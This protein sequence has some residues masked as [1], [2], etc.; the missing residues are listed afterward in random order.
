[1]LVK[2]RVSDD[3]MFLVA[4]LSLLENVGGVYDCRAAHFWLGIMYSH[5][6][7]LALMPFFIIAYF[8]FATFKLPKVILLYSEGEVMKKN[9]GFSSDTFRSFWTKC[10]WAKGNLRKQYIT[11]RIYKDHFK[12]WNAHL[13]LRCESPLISP[14][15]KKTRG[16]YKF[17]LLYAR[18]HHISICI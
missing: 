17:P 15:Y 8:T 12:G 2:K 16:E 11:H 10:W 1:M 6:H 9:M 3:G 13:P 7:F 18:H 5:Y 14:F 4:L